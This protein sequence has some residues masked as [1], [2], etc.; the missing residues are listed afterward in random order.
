MNVLSNIDIVKF[1]MSLLVIAIHTSKISNVDP[2]WIVAYLMRLAVPFFLIISGYFL[3]NL[4]SS[5]D[6]KGLFKVLYKY[7]QIYLVWI[8]LYMPFAIIYYLYNGFNILDAVEDYLWGVFVIGET[9]MAWHMWYIHSMIV[10]LL[11]IIVFTSKKVSYTKYAILCI[12]LSVVLSVLS[13]LNGYFIDNQ[14]FIVVCLPCICAGL[15]LKDN[16]SKITDKIVFVFF[17]FS[18][19]LFI[20]RISAFALLGAMV[21]A[22]IALR[23]KQLPVNLTYIRGISKYIYFVHLIP[24]FSLRMIS[25]QYGIDLDENALIYWCLTSLSSLLLALL[26]VVVK[27]K[28]RIIWI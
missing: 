1:L 7:L 23:M 24:A 19:V 14:N 6:I 10:S 17:I 27:S 9:P 2:P 3:H 12:I 18:V 4:I 20:F 22:I 26:I 8:L 13:N 28:Y 16:C 5:C 21:V 11:F 25:Q 15:L